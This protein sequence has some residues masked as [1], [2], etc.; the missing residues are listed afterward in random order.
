MRVKGTPVVIKIDLSIN[1]HI[2]RKAL[3]KRFPFIVT[4]I[5][6]KRKHVV[7]Q[8]FYAFLHKTS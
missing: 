6:T 2:E 7:H 5:Q 4:T 3:G 1:R 8:T